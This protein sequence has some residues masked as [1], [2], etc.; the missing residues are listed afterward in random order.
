M[1]NRAMA[2]AV[3]VGVV[4]VVVV[5]GI[6]GERAEGCGGRTRGGTVAT[7]GGSMISRFVAR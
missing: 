6:E 7:F 1:I 4:V 2:A 5:V 3:V